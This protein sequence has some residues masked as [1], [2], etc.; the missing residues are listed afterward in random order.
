M[1][2]S[3]SA[4]SANVFG[5]APLRTAG[6]NIGSANRGSRDHIPQVLVLFVEGNKM[7]PTESSAPISVG[8]VDRGVS[9]ERKAGTDVL[10]CLIS[11]AS[12]TR[13]N[14]FSMAVTEAG[15]DV[16]V[17]SSPAKALCE[18]QRSMFPFALVDLDDRGETPVGA[19]EL[20][21]TLAQD[22]SRILIGVCGHEADPEEEI[23]ARQLG[24]WLYL[25]GVTTSSEV[26]LLCEQA[27]QIVTKRRSE[28]QASLSSDRNS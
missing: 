6:M 8:Q 22:T 19:R 23:W 11:S 3:R 13:R 9:Q 17:C 21:Q 26:T 24:I 14:L 18:F 12:R 16:V 7:K 20:V 28:Q 4:P 27:L 2:H 10:Q 1:G 25:P 5:C 15:W